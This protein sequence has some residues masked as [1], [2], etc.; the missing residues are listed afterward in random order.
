MVSK[1]PRNHDQQTG[2]IPQGRDIFCFDLKAGPVWRESR[3]VKLC[4]GCCFL[5]IAVADIIAEGGDTLP[6]RRVLETLRLSHFAN[7][8]KE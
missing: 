3:V 4:V 8:T 1:G 5:W 2:T 6:W 7:T